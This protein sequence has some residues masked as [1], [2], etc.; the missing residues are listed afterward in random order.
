MR[1]LKTKEGPQTLK[2]P[3][4]TKILK[5]FKKSRERQKMSKNV[6]KC[7]KNEKRSRENFIGISLK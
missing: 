6:K 5:R 7:Q 1:N 2:H 3:N 4:T